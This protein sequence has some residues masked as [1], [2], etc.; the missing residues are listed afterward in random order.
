MSETQKDRRLQLTTPLG[1]DVL[2]ITSFVG[3]EE[4]SR[5]FTYELE[6]A[7]K[8]STTERLVRYAG[9]RPLSSYHKDFSNV[10]CY[11]DVDLLRATSG[12][13]SQLRL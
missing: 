8:N 9:E 3:D 1:E 10:I 11:H 12:W 5:S 4:L 13:Q 2:L 7:S 6:L